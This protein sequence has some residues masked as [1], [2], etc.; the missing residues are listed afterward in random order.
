MYNESPTNPSQAQSNPHLLREH[1]EEP[2]SLQ[3][4]EWPT[5]STIT[6]ATGTREL[7]PHGDIGPSELAASTK[8]TVTENTAQAGAG[9]SDRGPLKAF[10]LYIKGAGLNGRDIFSDWKIIPV[11]EGVESIC[12]QV[13]VDESKLS[14]HELTEKIQSWGAEIAK[15][16][17]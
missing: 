5:L 8:P 15:V 3:S 6:R 14:K 10:G 17:K 12:V 13:V 4:Q 1:R 7:V 9:S 11:A 16:F 2:P